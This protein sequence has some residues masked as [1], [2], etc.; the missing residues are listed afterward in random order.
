[1]SGTPLPDT[2]YDRIGRTYASQRRADPRIGAQLSSAL[3][4]A[5]SVLNVGAGTGSY[6]P[7]DR[8]V[9]ALEPS[10]VMLRQRAATAAPA[11]RGRAETLPFRANAFDAVQAV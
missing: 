4:T 7:P 5:R 1:M 11:I 3:G 8:A 6:E 9:L 2:V 10:A